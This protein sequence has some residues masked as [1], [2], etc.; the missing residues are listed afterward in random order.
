MSE[1]T[2][3]PRSREL[4]DSRWVRTTFMLAEDEI[5]GDYGDEVKE[6][7]LQWRVESS[8]RQ[9]FTNTRLGGNFTINNLPQY[10]RYADIRVAGLS[11][12]NNGPSKENSMGMGRFYGEQIDDNSQTVHLQFGLPEYNGM[13]SFF[14]SFFDN[15][16]SVMS[17]EGRGTITYYL[18]KAIGL[19]VSLA[20]IVRFPLYVMAGFSARFIMAAPAGSYYY[21]V[22][23]MPLYW[24]K[25]NLIAN[26]L[27]VNMG[28]VPRVWNNEK[29]ATPE[30]STIPNAEGYIQ[31]A[32]K[33][34]PDIFNDD[35]GINVYAVANKAQRLADE[36]YRL[37]LE[38]GEKATDNKDLADRLRKVSKQLLV[39]EKPK[40]MDRYLEEYHSSVIGDLLH[41]RTD[42][43]A[44][45]DVTELQ[46]S[47]NPEGAT[48]KDNKPTLF[49]SLRSKFIPGKDN[50]TEQDGYG[51]AETS[52]IW[53][54]WISNQRDGS[55]YISFRTDFSGTVDESFS[56]SVGESEISKKFN[57][58]SSTARSAR[59]TFS[60]GN[61]GIAPLDW[62]TGAVTDLFA[63]AIDGVSMG[64][65]L[66][67]AGSAFVD[68]PKHWENS[69][70]RLPTASY[71]IEL[72]TPYGNKLSRYI[73]LMVPLAC[74]LAGAL[75]HSTGKKSYNAP[76][77]CS[78]FCRG[79]SLIRNGMITD[80]SIT[81][82]TGNLGWN[83][84][85]ECLGIDISF[86]VTD[87]SSIMHMPIDSGSIL[88]WKGVIDADSGFMD[89]MGVLGNLSLADMTY[90]SRKL[91]LNLTRKREQYDSFFSKAHFANALDNTWLTRVVGQTI[92]LAL[93]NSE[94]LQGN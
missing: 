74:L 19:V 86:T 30:D 24:N 85:G 83:R 78:S 55:N 52:G 1:F 2:L 75:P 43:T 16:A 5:Y 63:G 64:G 67:L 39:G 69:T 17:S 93:R 9:K 50:P 54:Y 51:T 6:D 41:R 73:N 66:A 56:N 8:V 88:P 68:I 32:H 12:A 15:D 42:A 61:T 10:T 89:Y 44:K 14:T 7:L 53:D 4:R 33:N 70:A 91:A 71:T 35:G 13:L 92:S 28:L 40:T 57:G 90:P 65:F 31:Y 79:R 36:R 45:T 20:T 38:E 59:F 72:R 62:V 94:R 21:M 26:T 37:I 46:A 77:L 48:T 87:L 22:P 11:A 76:M 49:Q 82:G 3:S 47:E 23:R 27:A 58:F 25:V 60:E 81:R 80:L 29:G 18:G 34:A 84:N